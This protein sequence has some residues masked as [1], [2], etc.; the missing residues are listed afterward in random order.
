MIFRAT[1]AL[2]LILPALGLTQAAEPTTNPDIEKQVVGKWFQELSIRGFDVKAT[3][4]YHPDGKFSGEGVLTKGERTVN[5]VVTGS[6]KLEGSRLIEKVST[7][8]PPLIRR[9]REAAT[10]DIEVNDKALRFINEQGEEMT[11]TRVTE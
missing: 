7:C 4:T 11:K 2:S 5:M 8:T 3:T 6:W 9:G 10:E 1:V